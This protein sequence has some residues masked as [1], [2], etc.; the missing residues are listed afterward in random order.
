MIT[1]LQNNHPNPFN[2]NTTIQFSITEN[3]VKTELTIYNVKGQKVKNLTV[4][5]SGDEGSA[6]WNGD[7]ESG[8]PVSS[9]IYL[10]KLNVNGK[11]EAVK[12]CVLLK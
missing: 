12:K 9:G 5:M 2:P 6:S 4:I 3:L 1:Q 7:D 11:T 8:K 10:Y